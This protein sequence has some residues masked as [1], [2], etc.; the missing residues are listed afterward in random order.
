MLNDPQTV[1]PT[2]AHFEGRMVSETFTLEKFLWG[3]DDKGTFA[4][5]IGNDPAVIEIRLGDAAQN[6]EQA[7]IWTK[8]KQLN[9]PSL[10]KVLATGTWKWPDER[11]AYVVTEAPA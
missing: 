1:L 3:T 4:T 5:H 9:H 7:A 8:L 11:F 10:L 6:S 2:I